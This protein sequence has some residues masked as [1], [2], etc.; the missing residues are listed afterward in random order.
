[1][2][3]EENVDLGKRTTFR[4]GGIAKNLWVPESADEIAELMVSLKG[5]EFHVLGGGSNLP[6]N[7]RRTFDH[8]VSMESADLSMVD[9]GSGCFYLGASCRAAEAVK[10]VNSRG[11]GGFEELACL[12]AQFGGIVVMNAGIGGRKNPLFSISQFVSTVKVCAV[13]DGSIGVMDAS[14]CSFAHRHSAFQEGGYIVL[15][16][17]VELEPQDEEES[18]RRIQLRRE[19]VKSHQEWG[20]G[21]FGTCFCAAD[22]RL[23]RLARAMSR[24]GAPVYQSKGNSNWLVNRGGGTFEDAMAIVRRC[25]KLHRAFNR[26]CELEVKVWE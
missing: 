8:V 5:K 25:Q 17:T 16:A 12:P 21:C 18:K 26:E 3:R 2:R 4:V 11:Y 1:M 22:S 10:F 14:E 15:G 23:L 20:G 24:P 13:A 7:D 6:I 9:Q 19:F